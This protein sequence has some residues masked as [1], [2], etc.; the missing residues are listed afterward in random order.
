MK[1]IMMNNKLKTV[2]TDLE[3]IFTYMMLNDRVLEGT[4]ILVLLGY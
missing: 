1:R 3:K 2:L 4:S